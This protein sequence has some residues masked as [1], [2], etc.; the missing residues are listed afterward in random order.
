MIATQYRLMPTTMDDAEDA[1][2]MFNA[3]S[4]AMVGVEDYTTEDLRREWDT[5]GFNLSQDTRVVRLPDGKL[6]AYYEVWDSGDPHVLLFV[7]GR[8]LPGYE[9][10]ELDE[11]LQAWLDE[12]IGKALPL[13]P[14]DARV[15][16]RS[17]V[18]RNDT[19]T[20]QFLEK[21]GYRNIRSNYRMV[22]QLNGK[23]P[24]PE[25]PDGIT[26][27]TMV[28]GQDERSVIEAVRA[29]FQDHWGY[30]EHPFEEELERWIH[31]M[32]TNPDFDPSLWILAV[33]GDQI[34][35]TSLCWPKIHD[36]PDMGWVG[37]LGVIRPWRRKGLALALL[38][39]SFTKLYE[40]GKTRIGL[41]VDASSLTGATRLYE[42]AG[43]HSDPRFEYRMY[44][45]EIRP[46][47]DL[48]TQSLETS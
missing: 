21:A 13:S 6:I 1:V 19:S 40:R 36:D 31:M 15:A 3:H 12:R 17:F 34:V 30:V 28:R 43:M 32:D 4:L 16:V 39:H 27:R 48:T 22:I 23:P 10:P 37:T 33:D 2:R 20:R 35:G 7:W 41:G 11:V 5:P 47:I 26:I 46:G 44:E 18:N 24:T 42:K 45:K 29:S 25:L 38:Y 8:V 14:P 9:D